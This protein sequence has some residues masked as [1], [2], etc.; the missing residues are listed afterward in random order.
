[1]FKKLEKKHFLPGDTI[2]IF[3]CTDNQKAVKKAFAELVAAY[4]LP[5]IGCSDDGDVTRAEETTGMKLLDKCKTKSL[6]TRNKKV[7][8]SKVG[9][10]YPASDTNSTPASRLPSNMDDK[11]L[12]PESDRKESVS[13]ELKVPKD[14]DCSIEAGDYRIRHHVRVSWISL[15]CRQGSASF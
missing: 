13:L 5:E 15:Y 2:R 1:M 12:M 3:I 8:V 6:S 14:T 11:R 7:F 4:N 10:I 9:D